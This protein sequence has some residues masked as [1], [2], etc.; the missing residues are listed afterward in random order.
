[1]DVVMYFYTA[2]ESDKLLGVI[3]FKEV[4]VAQDTEPLKEL[5]TE[6]VISLNKMPP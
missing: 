6:N 5:M 1:M 3:D 2:D 4:F